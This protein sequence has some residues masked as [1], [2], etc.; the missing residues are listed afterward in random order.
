VIYA[1][2]STNIYSGPAPALRSIARSIVIDNH[3]FTLPG[4]TGENS[5][6]KLQFRGPQL[7]CETL[8]YNS[9]IPLES[10]DFNTLTGAV[11]VSEWLTD[12]LSFFVKQHNISSYSILH[13]AQN[14]TSYEAHVETVEQ[15]C[16]PKSVLYNVN[17]TFPRSVQKLE[18]HL[19]DEKELLKKW[20]DAEDSYPGSQS[21]STLSLILPAEPQAARD[22][23]QKVLDALPAFN[24]WALLDALG[25]LLK[26][27]YHEEFEKDDSS[28]CS[29]G[30]SYKNRTITKDCGERGF[31]TLCETKLS[32]N[33]PQAPLQGTVFQP[34][35]FDPK[36]GGICYDPRQELDIT[37]AL[38]ND[39]LTNITLS[40]ISLGTWWDIVPVNT[41]R[42]QSTYSFAKPLNLILPYSI[43]FATTAIFAA[44]AIWSLSHNGTP[45]ADG[46]FL[47]I[48]TATRGNTEME[49]LVLRESRL[50]TIEN[51]SA[52]LKKLKVR[53]GELV[54]ENILGVEGRRVGF[55]TVEETVSLRKSK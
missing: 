46:G 23:N 51:M 43:C 38:L 44:I 50:T 32:P 5:T 28:P 21:S 33:S 37:E 54:G 22:W 36:A 14:T 52:D 19:S 49:R 18:H 42:Y 15:S 3:V 25:S 34:A 7:R 16:G 48:M 17:V 4:H 27:E 12:S 47:Q 39:V 6:Y 10:T 1:L 13:S 26:G 8:H 31:V 11:F 41:T 40:A 45:A 20:Q 29:Q 2:F 55:G 9:S 30:N 35:R 24:E 53:Y